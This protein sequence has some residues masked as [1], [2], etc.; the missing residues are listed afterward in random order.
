MKVWDLAK[1]NATEKSV[2]E[3]S[4]ALETT[5]FF[6]SLL[7]T[8]HNLKITLLKENF[9]HFNTKLVN[10]KTQEAYILFQIGKANGNGLN[11]RDTF[12]FHLCFV[13]AFGCARLPALLGHG[14]RTYCKPAA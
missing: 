4:L 6:A 2:V 5:V 14:I 9:Q 11:V 10:S 8:C 12:V 3:K 13:S 7:A 1:I